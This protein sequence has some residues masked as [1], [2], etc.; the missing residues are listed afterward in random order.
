MVKAAGYYRGP[1]EGPTNTRTKYPVESGLARSAQPLLVGED[2]M[3]L[4]GRKVFLALNPSLDVL[5]DVVGLN[6]E[7]RGLLSRT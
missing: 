1:D 6:V 7:G 3:P 4:A 2:Q 5:Q